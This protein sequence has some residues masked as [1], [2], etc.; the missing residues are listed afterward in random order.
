MSLLNPKVV[1][2]ANERQYTTA[3]ADVQVPRGSVYE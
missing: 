3:G 1:Y 2:A